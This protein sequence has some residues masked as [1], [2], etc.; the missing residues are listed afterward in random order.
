MSQKSILIAGIVFVKPYEKWKV[1]LID[2]EAGNAK[3]C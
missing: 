3:L 1:K 2:S